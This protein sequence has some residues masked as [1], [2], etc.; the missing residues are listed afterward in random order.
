[1]R[2]AFIVEVFPKLSE[3][4]ILN[5]VTG[6]IDQGHEVEI[7]PSRR[8]RENIMHPRVKKYRLI[9]H[10]FFA[11]YLP[12]N[13]LVAK[14]KCM[15]HILQ[16]AGK[17]EV[18]SKILS[19]KIPVRFRINLFFRL[20]PFLNRAPFDIIH[21]HF[22]TM[23][24]IAV[25]GKSLD[26]FKGKMILSFYGY[27]ATRFTLDAGYYE[28]IVPQFDHFITI[29]NYL[30]EKIIKLGFPPEKISTIPIGVNL[31][32]WAHQRNTGKKSAIKLLTVARLVEKKGIYYSIM[33]FSKVQSMNCGLEYHIIGDGPLFHPLS[34]LIAELNL[35]N[36]VFLHGAMDQD[37]VKK[38]YQQADIFVLPSITASDGN[39]EGQ[40]LVLQEAQ[41]VGLPVVATFHNGIP[42]GVKDGETGFLVGERNI[43]AMAE[44]IEMLTNN[45]TLR[46]KMG[47]NG[48]KLI[49]KKFDNKV[50]VQKTLLLYA[51]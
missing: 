4:F 21:C 49:S 26:I 37:G 7:F 43:R 20:L 40:G 50:L 36:K 47:G 14:L 16:N 11:P 18:I 45:E 29:S 12:E 9:N 38:Y 22:G 6:L 13:K 48:I 44:K 33:A 3:T 23:G 28:S 39:S 30:R 51:Q 19:L 15:F 17:I 8:I 42:E 41:A 32:D 10:T 1:M 27:D 2:I 5:Q 35:Q 31:E 24:K 25:Y 46:Q 34:E